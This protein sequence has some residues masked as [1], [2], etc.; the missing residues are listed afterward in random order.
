[1]KRQLHNLNIVEVW[2]LVTPFNSWNLKTP[3]T[4]WYYIIL[5]ANKAVGCGI[6][7][8]IIFRYNTQPEVGNNVISGVTEDNIGMY[9]AVKFGDSRSNGFRDIRRA[10]FVSNERTWRSLSQ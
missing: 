9:V 7:W 3:L 6:F 8:T 10:D 5:N 1:M 2:R 4:F